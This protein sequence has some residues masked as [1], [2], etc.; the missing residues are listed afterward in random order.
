MFPT[1]LPALSHFVEHLMIPKTSSS[2]DQMIL[3]GLQTSSLTITS[4]PLLIW[5]SLILM[6]TGRRMAPSLYPKAASYWDQV[7]RL[8]S[9]IFSIRWRKRLGLVKFRLQPHFQ[10]ETVV[11]SLIDTTSIDIDWYMPRAWQKALFLI[12]SLKNEVN[13]LEGCI[14]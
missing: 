6:D 12:P 4:I 14:N 10:P 7:I 11:V 9:G 2:M 1:P 8:T 5:S 3:R 13:Q